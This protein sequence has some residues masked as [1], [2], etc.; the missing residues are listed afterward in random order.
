MPKSITRKLHQVTSNTNVIERNKHNDNPKFRQ[1]IC[2]TNYSPVEYEELA[3][4]APKDFE[5]IFGIK[6][7]DRRSKCLPIVKITNPHNGKCVYRAF[8]TSIEICGFNDYVGITYTAIR[9]ITDN[10]EELDTLD[11]VLLSK[12]SP[13]KFFW[14]HPNRATRIAIRM[15]AISIVLGVISVILAIMPFIC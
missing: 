11:I 12:G 4:L 15:G 1:P 2:I 5:L 3:F 14:R 6:D 8:R 10:K 13:I 7:G 9:E